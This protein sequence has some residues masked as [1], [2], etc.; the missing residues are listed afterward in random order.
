MKPLAFVRYGDDFVLFMPSEQAAV[1]AQRIATIWLLDNLRLR[2]HHQKNNAIF[3]THQGLYFLGH[4]VYPFSPI[5]IDKAMR[6]KV[7]RDI[8]TQNIA[9][10]QAMHLPRKDRKQLPWLVL[11][12]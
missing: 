8:N 10:Y 12:T 2:V 9:S 11:D 7:K 4:R 3:R 1:D 5:V 6:E